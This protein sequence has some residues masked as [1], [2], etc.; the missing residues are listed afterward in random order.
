MDRPNRLALAVVVALVASACGGDDLD[1]EA[2]TAFCEAHTDV[3]EAFLQENAEAAIAAVQTVHDNA[4]A[5]VAEAIAPLVS[6]LEEQGPAAFED[7]D[8]ED[9][10]RGAEDAADAFVL[11]SCDGDRLDVVALDYGYDNAPLELDAGT[12]LVNLTNTSATGEMHEAIFVRKNDGV[13]EGAVDIAQRPFEEIIGMV[14]PAGIV[15]SDGPDDTDVARVEMTPG[16]WFMICFIPVN[17]TGPESEQ[18]PP[19]FTEGMVR[20]FTVT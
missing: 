10:V 9:T 2:L 4:P 18:G 13:T 6:A 3:D 19:H 12:Y 15:F 1:P 7:P 11:D 14:A 17:S 8:L 5:D 20:E 16:D